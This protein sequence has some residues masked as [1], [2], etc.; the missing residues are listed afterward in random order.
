MPDNLS[1]QLINICF[2]TINNG[3]KLRL[4]SFPSLLPSPLRD[5]LATTRNQL[6]LQPPDDRLL[7]FDRLEQLIMGEMFFH[8]L[9]FL[10]GHVLF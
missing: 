7:R 3:H 9:L 5:R 2:L 8:E 10:E 1:L 6:L 4:S